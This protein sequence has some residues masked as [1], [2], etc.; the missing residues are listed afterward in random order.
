MSVAVSNA[1]FSSAISFLVTERVTREV[2]TELSVVTVVVVVV[3]ND[4]SIFLS[5]VRPDRLGD[6]RLGVTTVCCVTC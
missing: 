5:G 2:I 4:S 3:D 6:R 1:S